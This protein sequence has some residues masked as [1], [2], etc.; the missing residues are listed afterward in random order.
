M[1]TPLKTLSLEQRSALD[2]QRDVA[3]VHLLGPI[4]SGFVGGP[5][6]RLAKLEHDCEFVG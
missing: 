6:E 3:I 4:E 1:V 5:Q 2:K